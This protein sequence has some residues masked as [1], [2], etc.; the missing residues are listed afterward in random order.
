MSRRAAG[1][2]TTVA[3]LAGVLAGCGASGLYGLPLPGGADLGD[4]PYRVTVALADALDLVPQASVRIG[5]VPVGRVDRIDLAPDGSAALATLTVNGGVVLPANT[6]VE[7]R[8]ASLLGEKFIELEPPPPA[9]A[10]G[11]LRDGAVIPL[12]ATRRYPEVE[13]VFGALSLLLNGGGVAQLQDIVRELNTATTG[14]EPALR[15]LLTRLQQTTGQLDAR[16]D[17]IVAAI[18]ALDRLSTAFAAQTPHIATALD[19]LE[20]GLAE[21]AD[22][23]TEL[24]NAL[25]SLD[26]LSGVAVDTV[27][28]SRDDLLADLRELRP[29]LEQLNRAGS[30]IPNSLQIL[31]TYPFTEYAQRT[32]R[33]DYTNVDVQVDLDLSG[34]LGNLLRSSQPVVPIPGT[35]ANPLPGT[36]ASPLLEPRAPAGLG[37]LLSPLLSGG[38]R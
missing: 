17:T 32:F 5:D 21:L 14:N 13:E 12:A 37:G 29:T 7:L 34:L 19:R 38:D 25:T 24:V 22:Q 1:A 6:G 8:S 11:R 28:R 2:L 26:R 16:R 4:R 30:D 27:H 23:R 3:L 36:S 18:N 9:T 35:A 10:T 15:D 33:G 31:L 20:P